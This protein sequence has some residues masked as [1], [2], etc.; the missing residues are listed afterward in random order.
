M[1]ISIITMTSTYNYGATLQAYALQ[2]FIQELGHECNLIDHL[3]GVDKQ[4]KIRLSNLSRDNL[5]KIPYK[6]ILE[7][8]YRK[9][10]NF[11]DTH[12]NMT[13]RYANIEEL[14]SN[15][16]DSDV[17]VVGSDQ[18]WN[19]RDPKIDRFFL[20]FVPR[21][22]CKIS[23]AASMGDPKLPDELKE[24]YIEGL[25]SFSG[26]S[27]REQE[28]YEILQDLTDKPIHVNCD[29][30]FLLTAEEWRKLEVPVKG[31]DANEYILCYLIH[32]PKWFNN[33][34][35]KFRK[36]TGLKIICVGLDGYRSIYCDKYIRDAGI[37]EWLWLIDN[38]K[39]VVSSSFHGNVFSLIFGKKL[40]SM[41][42][43]KRSDR[44]CNLLK[45]FRESDR[46]VY[47]IEDSIVNRQLDLKIIE[48]I[49]ESGREKAREYLKIFFDNT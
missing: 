18:V 3:S 8:G 4:R 10:E 30:A 13:N 44:I 20:D 36:Q 6:L 34:A 33:W 38:A 42:D 21:D 2:R 46:I 12:M 24:K 7:K 14:K 23:Y 26:I 47:N 15:P 32:R 35:K 25:K 28:V 37:G 19:P 31:M 43:P 11:Y 48:Q 40:I 41:P 22:K 16:P 49:S 17:F 29:P 9:F 39:I 5:V 45:T 1:K 27:V